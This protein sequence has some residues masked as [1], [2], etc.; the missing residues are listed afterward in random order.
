MIRKLKESDKWQG[1]FVAAVFCWFIVELA[2][3]IIPVRAAAISGLYRFLLLIKGW[4]AILLIALIVLVIAAVFYLSRKMVFGQWETCL[5]VIYAFWLIV[6]RIVHD[7]AIPWADRMLIFDYFISFMMLV[8]GIRLKEKQRERLLTAVV[9]SYGSF[10]TIACAAGLF[11]IITDS[12]LCVSPRNDIWIRGTLDAGLTNLELLSTH[13]N[14]SAPRVYMAI[15]LLLYALIKNRKNGVRVLIFLCVVLLHITFATFHSRTSLIALALSYGMFA[16]MLLRKALD[17]K[18]NFVRI[19]LL[20]LIT[21]AVIAIGYFS[22]GWSNAIVSDLRSFCAPRFAVWYDSFEYKV[23]PSVF[24]VINAPKAQAEPVALNN[25]LPPPQAAALAVIKPD[26]SD[27]I[28]SAENE[29]LSGIMSVKADEDIGS[30]TDK[31]DILSNRNLSERTYIWKAGISA[32]SR[33]PSIAL[34]GNLKDKLMKPVNSILAEEGIESKPHMHNGYMQLLMMT[35]I[36]GLLPVLIWTIIIVIKMMKVWFKKPGSVPAVAQ[37]LVVP[38]AG[39]FIYELAEVHVFSDSD[40][41]AKIFYLVAGVFLAYYRDYS[42][43]VSSNGNEKKTSR[44]TIIS[45]CLILVYM[46]VG[47]FSVWKKTVKEAE[48]VPPSF[49]GSKKTMTALQFSHDSGTYKEP[50]FKVTISAPEGYTVAYTTDSTAPNVDNDSG[51]STV[52]VLIKSNS[53]GYLISHRDEMLLADFD[54]KGFFEDSSLPS[55]VVLTAAVVDRDGRVSNSETRVYY[56]GMD[57]SELFPDCIVISIT[58]DPSNLLDYET[59]ILATGVI[60][61]EWKQT[62]KGKKDIIEKSWWRSKTNSTQQGKVW[63]RPCRIQLY[64]GD[65]IPDYEGAAGIRVCGGASRNRVQKSFNFYFR[66]EYGKKN[67][68][69]ELFPGI[70]TFKSFSLKAG[71][72][73]TDGLKYKNV[74]INELVRGRDLLVLNARPA[75][76]FLNGEYWGPYYLRE[77]PS[78][79]M[80][81]SRLGVDEDQVV[82]IKDGKLEEGGESDFI[83]YEELLSFAEKDLSDPENY[84]EFCSVMDIKSMADYFAAQIYIGNCDFT[85]NVNNMLWRTRDD[86][87]I[88]GRWQ[89]I[90]YDTELSSGLNGSEMTSENTDH[91]KIVMEKNALFAIAI[92]NRDFYEL[93]LNYIKEIGTEC[94]SP[95]RVRQEMQN[96][97]LIW[98]SLMPGFYK[99]YGDYSKAYDS[100]RKRM[101]QFFDNRYDIIIPIIEEWGRQNGLYDG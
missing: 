89:Y 72:N 92:K 41:I 46:L 62:D 66:S 79:H 34:F 10:F 96:Y 60:Y 22:Y 8:A 58:T 47:C 54:Q 32:I 91:L 76:L 69:H 74:F 15:M 14:L 80:L 73:T 52:N 83:L 64:D 101:I 40:V 97:E 63:E 99:R 35:G 9:I 86:S 87:Y 18:H 43:K 90:M 13:R 57:F 31:R 94:Y 48:S 93:F 61:D 65:N 78:A 53:H 21:A 44:K 75:V 45:L 25:G 23:D 77:K 37:L 12:A 71:G 6:T 56:P 33:N 24:S 2:D 1:I 16:F 38:L 4:K 28:S 17:R 26:P 95:D 42:E 88:A 84:K 5:C 39:I 29:K 11:V 100:N 55:G 19:P 59:G 49:Y 85:L 98:G 20:S 36:P 51:L 67:L 68:E 81:R 82:I 70:V 27:R 3:I 30:M 50:E 7:K